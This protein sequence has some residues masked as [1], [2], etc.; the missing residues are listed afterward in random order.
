[1]PA[2]ADRQNIEIKTNSL[3]NIICEFEVVY[4]DEEN[5]LTDITQKQI[6]VSTDA[7]LSYPEAQ[8]QA[9]LAVVSWEDQENA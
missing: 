9:L 5:D 1:M 6:V 7:T 2:V 3:G 4:Y 8:D